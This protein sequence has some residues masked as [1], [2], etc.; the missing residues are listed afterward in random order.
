ME[1]WFQH[2]K[3]ADFDAMAQAFS[4]DK[5]TARIIRNRD[6]VSEEDVKKYLFGTMEEL[7]PPRLM[8]DVDKAVGIITQAIEQKKKI[9]V[10][11]D[12]DIDGVCSTYILVSGLRYL[13]ADV[14]YAI[15]N[16][17]KDG[18]GMNIALVEEAIKDRV[19]LIITCDNGISAYEQIAFAVSNG[20]QVVVTDH[21]EVPFDYN[22]AGEKIYK[23]P[24]AD[25]VV[26][27]KQEDCPY[28][29][30]EICGCVVAWKVMQ[31]LFMALGQE[32]PEDY[33][34]IAAFATIGDVMA[35]KD[36]NRIIVKYGLKK[37][38]YTKNQG[39]K[40]LIDVNQLA[41]KDIKAYHVGFVLG[42]CMNATG[43]L[44]SA[45]RAL[46]M[47]LSTKRNEA[48]VIAS[49]LKELNDSRK[50]M[51]VKN[52]Q[53]AVSQIEES[54]LIQDKVLVVY[55]ADCHES[56]AGIIAGRL[57]EKYDRPAFVLTDSMEGVKGSGRSIEAYDMYEELNKCKDL[58]TKFGGHKM[59]AG[60]SLERE[61][62]DNLRNAL[63]ENTTLTPT[64]L[65]NRVYIDLELPMGYVTKE[66]IKEF[67]ML[68]PFGDGN[69][70]PVFALRNL[71]FLSMT[72]FGKN[73]NVV[74]FSVEE[75]S[76]SERLRHTLVY[77][78]NIEQFSS[79]VEEKYSKEQLDRLMDGRENEVTLSVLY[80]PSINE[81]MGKQQIQ[82]VMQGYK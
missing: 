1:Q 81:Y 39:L 30:K 17:I 65:V 7:Y 57:R 68:E 60:L 8:K 25:A 73:K 47:L 61:D 79:Y 37:M 50:D 15:P 48:I 52:T 40:A 16:R 41:G 6:I 22:E 82:Y 35:L 27:P 38:P 74:R 78:G 19:E 26:D 63:N 9:R 43:R 28:P 42:P 70:K 31:A 67:D 2:M 69:P 33:L 24:D 77:F 13:L 58:L 20:V 4:I 21:H 66:L 49:E 62:V 53:L 18:Y 10:I 14:D 54:S 46:D 72:V 36:E 23:I 51:T 71:N 59:A 12:Y 5:V 55:L 3:K 29:F 75:V 80:Y 45:L 44:D 34:E 64:D 76:A 56:L 11:G 32:E